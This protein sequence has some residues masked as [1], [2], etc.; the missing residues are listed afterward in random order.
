MIKKKFCSLLLAGL[1]V[2]SSG[3]V[4]YAGTISDNNPSSVIPYFV[5]ISMINTNLLFQNGN[6][7]CAVTVI[8]PQSSADKV[9]FDITLY[10]QSGSAWTAIKSWNKT[11]TVSNSF[12]WFEEMQSVNSGYNYL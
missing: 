9:K 1:L 10:R 4:S 8:V 3:A 12:A 2:A 7:V 5:A 11:A 6:A